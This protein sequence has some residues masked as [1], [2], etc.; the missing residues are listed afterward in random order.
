MV[1]SFFEM[2]YSCKV[3]HGNEDRIRW[4]PSKK[5]T[6]EVKLFYKALSIPDYVVFPWKSIWHSDVPPRVAFLGGLQLSAKC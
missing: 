3:S 5:V 2:L 6:F 1:S 4:S